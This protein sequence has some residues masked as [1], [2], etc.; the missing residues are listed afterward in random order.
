M[1]Y[2]RGEREQEIGDNTLLILSVMNYEYPRWNFVWMWIE[3]LECP[4]FD[5]TS[6]GLTRVDRMSWS[7]DQ[8]GLDWSCL[9]C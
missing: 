7:D 4:D 1:N 8:S 6:M 2:G 3:V 5:G 9:V